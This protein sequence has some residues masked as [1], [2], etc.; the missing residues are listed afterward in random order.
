MEIRSGGLDNMDEYSVS[1]NGHGFK[2]EA[3]SKSVAIKKGVQEYFKAFE[4]K[5]DCDD[6]RVFVRKLGV[7]E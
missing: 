1:V 2:V 4:Q 6:F 5:K 3:G 7:E